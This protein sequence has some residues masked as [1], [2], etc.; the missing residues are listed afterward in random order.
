MGS[1]IDYINAIGIGRIEKRIRALTDFLIGK[2][3]QNGFQ[4]LSP[5]RSEFRSGIVVFYVKNAEK[6]T[7]RLLARRIYVSPRGG[8]IRVA[9]HCYN[10]EAEISHLIQVLKEEMK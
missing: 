3:D 5:L 9:P 10:T 8:G 6:L 7:K 4:I 1:A 2:L